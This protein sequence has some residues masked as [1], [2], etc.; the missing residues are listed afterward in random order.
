MYELNDT[1]K[2]DLTALAE[3]HDMTYHSLAF[4]ISAAVDKENR[5]EDIKYVL[6]QG[7]YGEIKDTEA[8]IALIYDRLV[9]H[10]DAE[11][12]TWTNIENAIDWVYDDLE[13]VD[14]NSQP[15]VVAGL[16][17]SDGSLMVGIAIDEN[18][19]AAIIKGDKKED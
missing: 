13:K 15:T 8:N 1:I 14:D 3:K 7:E 6:A 4:A 12:G 17:R 16:R 5:I 18:G 2:A 9:S 11:Y 10:E 19:K